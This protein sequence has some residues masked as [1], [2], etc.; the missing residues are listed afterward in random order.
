L[1]GTG[2]ATGIREKIAKSHSRLAIGMYISTQ[3][4][5]LR[6][7][8]MARNYVKNKDRID[9]D[10]PED[11]DPIMGDLN[12]VCPEE[13]KND[14]VAHRKWRET[15]KIFQEAKL[16]VISS[17]DSGIIGRYCTMY[18]EY[19][20]LIGRRKQLAAFE[21]PED[22]DQEMLA[23][24]EYEYGREKAKRLWRILEYFTSLKGLTEIDKNINA[25][26]KTLTDLEDKLF[27]TPASKA[28][29]LKI[30]K[31]SSEADPLKQKGFDNV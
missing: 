17:T 27:L 24:T 9:V 25:K 4:Y 18:S 19:I 21:L 26:Q 31:K 15:I 23:I 6:K 28:R 7:N 16:D 30:K 3:S 29:K 10:I 22:N 13:V 14:V 8:N 11:G 2:P 1:L 20:E 5:R 12:F